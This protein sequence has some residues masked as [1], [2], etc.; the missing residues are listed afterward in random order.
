MSSEILSVGIDIGTST[1]Q[2]I[3]SKLRMENLADY[4]SAPRISIVAK[5][6]VYKSDVHTTPLATPVL[7]DGPGVRKIVE[8]E[9]RKAGYSPADPDTGAVIITGE[10][11]R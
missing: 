6:L 8:E 11:A 4:F 10:S 1:T 7:L 2:V 5:E 3:F 9:Y